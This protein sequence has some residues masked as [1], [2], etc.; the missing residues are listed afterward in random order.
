MAVSLRDKLR[1]AAPIA[2]KPAASQS[3]SCMQRQHCYA[4]ADQY[5]QK[6][7]S[8]QVLT[9]MQGV[10]MP[11]IDRENILFLDTETTGLSG[12]AGTVAFLVGVGYFEADE[13]K[14]VQYLMRDYDEEIHVLERVAEHMKKRKV[15]CT[16]N[17]VT[18]DV[19]LLRS[20]SIMQRI[21][22][23]EPDWHIDLLHASR[24]VW[25]LRLKRCNLTALEE[26][27]LGRTRVDDLPGALVPERYFRFLKE[28]NMEL[29]EDVLEH[30][31]QDIA[32]LTDILRKLMALH[33][34][35]LD[36]GF[37]EDIYSLGRIYE[38]RGQIEGARKCYRAAS[39][40]NTLWASQTRLAESLRK[41]GEYEQAAKAYEEALYVRR[42]DVTAHIALAKLYEHRI[43]DLQAALTHTRQALLLGAETDGMDLAPIQKRYE[44]IM[45]KLRRND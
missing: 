43:H 12:G 18:F 30:N 2:K 9:L 21:R 5:L 39:K 4:Q 17:G 7:L 3:Q 16:F 32:S 24:R 37:T 8:G 14:V 38:K 15:L 29:L 41:T 26:A 33:E 31:Q 28:R 22:L 27:V 45:M 42:S 23:P 11:D 35:P 40:G 20:R 36:A 25:K 10:N 6:T 34:K 19:P 1:S 13:L 44:R